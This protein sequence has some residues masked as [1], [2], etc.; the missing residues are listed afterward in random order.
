MTLS[1]EK[2][3]KSSVWG[4]WNLTTCYKPTTHYSQTRRIGDETI[5]SPNKILFAKTGQTATTHRSLFAVNFHTNIF[6]TENF[7]FLMKNSFVFVEETATSTCEQR[8]VKNLFAKHGEHL[9]YTIRCA[10]VF[11]HFA[12]V[13]SLFTNSV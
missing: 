13:S 4:R 6:A 5:F 10:S 2:W 9:L 7:F 1:A 3:W 12:L 11:C 8:T